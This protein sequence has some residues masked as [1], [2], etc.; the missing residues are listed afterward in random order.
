MSRRAPPAPQGLLFPGGGRP[1]PSPAPG[2][3]GGAEEQPVHGQEVAGAVAAGPVAMDLR[4]A[5]YNAARDGK[6]KLLQKLLGSRSREELE[7]LTA[8]PGG[9]TALGEGAPRC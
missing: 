1:R 6:L 2:R 9:V 4:T 8:G 7:A 3:A 5:V